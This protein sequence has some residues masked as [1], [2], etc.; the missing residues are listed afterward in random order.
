MVRHT[1]YQ[2]EL[3]QEDWTKKGRPFEI[4]K[5]IGPVTYQLK[6]PT[7]WKIHPIFHATLLRQYKEM[8]VYGVNFPR[9]PP[10]VIEGEE[11]Y[12]VERI[13][14]HQKHG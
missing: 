8:D 2:D 7:T 14:K 12:E 1:E 5:V 9:P 10:D 4:S 6:L 13:L 11:V 3:S